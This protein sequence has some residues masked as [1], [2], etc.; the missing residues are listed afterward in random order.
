MRIKFTLL[1]LFITTNY[2]SFSAWE[3][4]NDGLDKQAPTIA[5][6]KFVED[7]LF[8]SAS[9]MLG[10]SQGLFTSTN[11][12]DTWKLIGLENSEITSVTKINDMY[13]AGT[14]NDGIYF[15]SDGG[16][17]WEQRNI[18]LPDGD[19]THVDYLDKIGDTLIISVPELYYST[20]LG[21]TWNKFASLEGISCTYL[22]CADNVIMIGA[23]AGDIGLNNRVSSDFGET[24]TETNFYTSSYP[25][26]F[27]KYHN[28]LFFT[29]YTSYIYS[30]TNN[31]IDWISS[32]L[33][34]N[35]IVAIGVKNDTLCAVS[36]T[37]NIFYSLD[38]GITY[39][40]SDMSHI[41]FDYTVKN[42]AISSRIIGYN[43][44]DQ[45]YYYFDLYWLF[46][47][48]GV[49]VQGEVLNISRYL[50]K[51]IANTQ[52]G[53][54]TLNNGNTIW[55]KFTSTPSN[56]DKDNNVNS[57]QTLDDSKL[58]LFHNKSY[59]ISE[60]DGASWQ[61][62]KMNQNI[63]SYTFNFYPN[64]YLATP[65]TY[66]M[67][68]KV[69]YSTDKGNSWNPLLN[70][71]YGNINTGT[72]FFNNQIFCYSD[73]I[74]MQTTSD[75][76]QTWIRKNDNLGNWDGHV[77]I[78]DSA[79]CDSSLF[80]IIAH[81]DF[82]YNYSYVLMKSED[83]GETYQ[84][85]KTDIIW[86]KSLYNVQNK[87]FVTSTFGGLYCTTDK[88]ETWIDKSEGIEK[89]KILGIQSL[90]EYLY[91]GT[92]KGVFREQGAEFGLGI[93][94]TESTS[95]ISIFPNPASST[96]NLTGVSEGM[97]KF[98]IFD[99]LGNVVMTVT[100]NNTEGAIYD[101]PLR[102]DVSH[103]LP[104]VYLVQIGDEVKKFVKI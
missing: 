44:G 100:R 49:N 52:N 94:L 73:E 55:E 1:I 95:D 17:N 88:G 66:A 77:K 57:V 89:I 15:T 13:F 22:E 92:N 62:F 102:I 71:P 5:Y 36:S 81:Y 26:T 18:G 60:D 87:L 53:I 78:F 68:H 101:S 10:T 28:K 30:S 72:F 41:G 21:F 16:K 85:V 98:S 103:L 11:F 96:I 3:P 67:E 74:G 76:G 82:E 86:P 65:H 8:A 6:M 79:I 20:D 104:G 4:V 59:S 48:L 84:T 58:I 90:G 45:A 47:D 56:Q 27:I 64:I 43:V 50:G 2:I 25:S 51:L 91:I 29:D 83:Y 39:H 80:L 46:K 38:D 23:L 99:V 93:N 12:G 24:W 37:G 54:F 75:Y 61:Q 70:A 19:Q 33:P 35:F 14:Y 42:A 7:Q 40:K 34:Q 32:Q 31:G 97:T 9:N 63:Y 69:K